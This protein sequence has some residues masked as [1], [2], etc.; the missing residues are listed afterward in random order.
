[1][2]AGLDLYFRLAHKHRLLETLKPL[3]TI[4]P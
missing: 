3:K 1:M 4:G 2:R